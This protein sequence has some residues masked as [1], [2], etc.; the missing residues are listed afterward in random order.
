MAD[1]GSVGRP[2][3]ILWDPHDDPGWTAVLARM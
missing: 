3:T 1:Q 2:T